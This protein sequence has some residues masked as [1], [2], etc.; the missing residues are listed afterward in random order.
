MRVQKQKIHRV[1][2]GWMGP[3]VNVYASPLQLVQWLHMSCLS[4]WNMYW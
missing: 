4:K 1:F 2:E 3:M